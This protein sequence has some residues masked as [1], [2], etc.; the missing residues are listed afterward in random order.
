M[1]CHECLQVEA[2]R[3]AGRQEEEE[4]EEEDGCSLHRPLPPRITIL[5][6]AAT[7]RSIVLGLGGE[8]ICPT[9]YSETKTRAAQPSPLVRSFVPWLVP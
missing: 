5:D 3:Q 8:A 9:Q 7:Q 6:N 2:G 4:E 1:K